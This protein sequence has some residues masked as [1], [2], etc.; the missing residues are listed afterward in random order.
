MR[1]PFALLAVLA[2]ACQSP[3]PEVH[4]LR[5]WG[6]ARDGSSASPEP[7]PAPLPP[8]P[9]SAAA[10]TPP[11]P[12][13]WAEKA[14]LTEAEM[15]EVLEVS[16]WPTNLV[17][18]ATRVAWCES[19]FRPGAIGDGGNVLGLFQLWSGWFAYAGYP[20]EDWSVALTN[21]AVA[22]TV[23]NYDI[24][25]GRPPWASWSCKP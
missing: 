21:A 17:A 8:E 5:V 7:R 23:Y 18:A 6:L 4:T 13:A 15:G 9:P 20:L 24:A 11:A 25:H 16:G 3:P 10:P 14:Q 1:W 19:R 2:V 22:L 12:P